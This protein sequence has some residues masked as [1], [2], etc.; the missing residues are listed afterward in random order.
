MERLMRTEGEL[1]RG[2]LVT[3][4]SGFLAGELL[5][6]LLDT[7]RESSIY[8]LLRAE[9]AESMAERRRSILERVGI[10]ESERVVALAGDMEQADLGLGA[11]YERFAGNMSEIYH[12]AACTRF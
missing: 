7:Y 9:S 8:L 10:S 11:G 1:Q 5:P 2:I 4:A 6:R 3:G 12:S